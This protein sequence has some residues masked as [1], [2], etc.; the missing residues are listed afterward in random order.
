MVALIFSSEIEIINFLPNATEE[1]KIP[2][3]HCFSSIRKIWAMSTRLIS[4][5]NG[6]RYAHHLYLLE[7]QIWLAMPRAPMPED[8]LSF[9]GL[10][11]SSI[12]TRDN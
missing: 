4:F 7:C 12:G 6:R 2:H 3:F 11:T 9:L 1:Q 10:A 8:H 5:R